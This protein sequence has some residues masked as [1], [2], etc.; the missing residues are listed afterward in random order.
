MKMKKPRR[1]THHYDCFVVTYVFLQETGLFFL[2]DVGLD[3]VPERRVRVELVLRPVG[4]TISLPGNV[5][6]EKCVEP[7]SQR[8]RLRLA[9]EVDGH[10]VAFAVGEEIETTPEFVGLSFTLRGRAGIYCRDRVNVIGPL[11]RNKSN[12]V[13]IVGGTSCL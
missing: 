5:L 12:T 7:H 8:L 4:S 6:L 10:D 11:I 13:Y 2:L 9:F 3:L 1:S